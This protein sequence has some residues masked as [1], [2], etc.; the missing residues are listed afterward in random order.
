MGPLVLIAT[1]AGF[2]SALMAATIASGG[3]LA[4]PL[5]LLAPL[6]LV[7]VAI[8][9]HPLV[10]LLGGAITCALLSFFFAG[11]TALVFAVLVAAPAWMLGTIVWQHDPSEAEGV[12]SGKL[13]V[14]AAIYG[15]LATMIG[16]F[17]VSFDYSVFDARL[18]RQ[19]EATLRFMMGVAPEAPLPTTAGATSEALVRAYATAVPPVSTMLLGLVYIVNAYVAA[20]VSR[21][22]G[23]LPVAWSDVPSVMVPRALLLTTAALMLLAALPGWIG[24]AA[25]LLATAATLVLILLGFATLHFL[26]RDWGGRLALLLVV[27]MTTAIFG[28]PALIMFFLGVIELS[29]GLR[30]RKMAG[31]T[32]PP[33]A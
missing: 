24:L 6:P 21:A 8:G 28:V 30:R 32:K 7:I 29:F 3:A 20:R 16:A 25:E 11:Q 9:W 26:T 14:A 15:A 10:S 17:S 2:A 5:A 13:L 18:L 23:R 31:G 12:L 33:N 22:S 1:G 19:A 27:W 4:L